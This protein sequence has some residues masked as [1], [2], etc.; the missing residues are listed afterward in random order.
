MPLKRLAV[1]C[2]PFS[3]AAG[4]HFVKIGAMV[5]P[6]C[7]P[8][9]VLLPVI[10]FLLFSYAASAQVRTDTYLDPMDQRRHAAVETEVYDGQWRIRISAVGQGVDAMPGFRGR[11]GANIQTAFEINQ[12]LMSD[13]LEVVTVRSSGESQGP[14]YLQPEAWGS[15]PERR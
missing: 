5:N 15:V 8:R 11:A 7:T 2:V 13:R 4:K 14:W 3:L 10:V 6:A 9:F 1:A 12:L